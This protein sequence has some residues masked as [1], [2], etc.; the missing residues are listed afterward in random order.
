MLPNSRPLRPIFLRARARCWLRWAIYRAEHVRPRAPRC[1][2][3][4]SVLPEYRL[5]E[6]AQDLLYNRRLEEAA[7]AFRKILARD[8]NNTLARRDL[9][10]TYVELHSYGKARACFEQVVTE[11]PDDY[12]AQFELGI[13]DKNLGLTDQ[14]REHL[15]IACKVAPGA[16]QCR[17]ELQDLDKN[18][19]R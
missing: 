2:I 3:R 6:Q 18:F 8:P 17:R 11:V 4:K 12:M 19:P 7:A 5:Y 13:A 1:P 15:H 14:A 16:E 9:G 10:G